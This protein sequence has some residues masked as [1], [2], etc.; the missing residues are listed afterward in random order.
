MSSL[1]IKIIDRIKASTGIARILSDSKMGYS[2]TYTAADLAD[3]DFITKAIGQSF[4]AGVPTLSVPV[5][6]TG[7]PI[8]YFI[9]ISLYTGITETSEVITKATS[10]DPITGIATGRLQVWNDMVVEEQDTVGDGTGTFTG[11]NI[12]G[13]DDGSGNFKEDTYV[14]LKG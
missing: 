5:I 13:H 11:W 6:N 1:I 10:Y 3:N 4:A 7:T 14:I 12:Y 2:N 9:D 8:P